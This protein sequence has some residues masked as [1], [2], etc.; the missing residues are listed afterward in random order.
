MLLAILFLLCG[1]V[2][3]AATFM[4]VWTSAKLGSPLFY[5]IVGVTLSV[6]V[7]VLTAVWNRRPAPRALLLLAFL[8]AGAVRVPL[9]LPNVGTDN[10]M[11]RY[12]W[13]GRV[14]RMG[15]NPYH[16]LPA[17]PAL[18][19][20]HNDETRSMPSARARTPYPPA[21]QLFFRLVVTIHDSSRA[22][23]LALVL[24]DLL[25][26]LVVWRWLAVTGRNEWLALAYGWSPFV[27]LEV[28][29]SGHIDA[30]GALWIAACAYFLARRRTTLASIV[31]VAAVATKLLPIVLAPLLWK[32][33]RLR[34]AAIGGALFALFYLPFVWGPG[35]PVGAMPSVV[36]GIRFNG[37]I[38]EAISAITFPPVAAAVAVLVG[39]GVAWWARW[40][41]DVANPAAW[42]WPMAA[43]LLSAPVIY[44]W[45]LLYLTPFLVS[46]STFPILVWSF[47]ILLTYLVW[48]VPE[49]RLPWVVPAWVLAVEY[50]MVI[51]AGL[52]VWLWRRKPPAP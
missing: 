36:A 49:Y 34:D 42:A 40:T 2:Y 25:T 5:T 29:H 6:Y 8:L 1:A 15:Y 12:V 37:P 35:L 45:Y 46:V 26:M 30:L 51:T 44:P 47:T 27:V 50:G 38:F 10:D 33:V 11:M 16:V 4:L 9:L 31:F 39:L 13:D 43:A 3:T 28:A 22:M 14:Q 23:K 24:C 17:D 19:Y 52:S 7:I 32:R 21:A 18:A 20:T 48:F 41:R